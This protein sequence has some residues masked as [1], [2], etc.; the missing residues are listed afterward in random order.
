MAAGAVVPNIEGPYYPGAPGL[1]Q[2][3]QPAGQ[4]TPSGYTWDEVQKR[5]VPYAG[6]A[7]AGQEDLMRQRERQD[8]A[9]RQQQE[10][11]GKFATMP[12]LQLPQMPQMAGVPTPPPA[13]TFQPPPTA[14]AGVLPGRESFDTPALNAADQEI[15]NRA[16][17]QQGKI[18]R[19]ALTGLQ[20]SLAGRGML[21]GGRERQGT[22]DIV[23]QGAE[24]LGNLT[25]EQ[26]IQQAQQAQRNA[27]TAFQGGI[28]QRGQD[29]SA[30]QS[31][32]QNALNAWRAQQEAQLGQYNASLGGFRTGLDALQ[33]QQQMQLNQYNA[34]LDAQ[35]ANQQALA[36]LLKA[37]Y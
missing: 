7:R 2:S 32:A 27:E 10:L 26:A 6:S 11:F 20:S 9:M 3:P 34:Q 29:I 21:G 37:I 4:K 33:T 14:T 18:A 24:A 22:S 23:Q 13:P 1:Y 17:D 36:G 16:K 30:N 35:R 31:N 5:Y 8:A 15:F 25:R 12:G 19:S 28:T